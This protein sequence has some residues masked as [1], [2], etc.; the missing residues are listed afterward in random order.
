MAYN[1]YKGSMNILFDAWTKFDPTK[2]ILMFSGGHDSLVST[3]VCAS[4]FATRSIPFEIYHGDTTI[5][6]PETQDYVKTVCKIYGWKLN[7]RKPP[8]KQRGY[9]W[10]VKKF[11]FPGPTKSSHQMCYRWLKERALSNFVTHE[12]K[13]TPYARQSIMLCTG[14]RKDESRI[15]M[16]YINEVNKEHSKIWVNPIFHW[17]EQ[18]CNE[19]LEYND[20]PKNPVKEKMCIS[21]ECLCGCFARKEE[22]AEL[23]EAYPE[24][25]RR[26]EQLHELAKENGHPWPWGFGPT[27]WYKRNPKNQLS[28]FMC[29]GC[30]AKK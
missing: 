5:G 30:E 19:Y 4:F 8:N 29:V 14:V 23:K 11:G 17:S 18:D 24:T 25:A 20:L 3:H 1:E 22:F 27:Q 9:E 7:I 10:I 6:I 12:C 2:I 26:I 16:G 21:G 15:R 28:M 13:T